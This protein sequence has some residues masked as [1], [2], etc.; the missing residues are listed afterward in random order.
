MV[1][2]ILI[3]LV[4][5]FIAGSTNYLAIK[6]LFRPRKPIYIF[7]KRLPFTPGII[8]KNR[9]RIAAALAET[10]E[11][12]FLNDEIIKKNLKF[13]Y[14]IN[15]FVKNLEN[16]IPE[17]LAL[18]DI[19]HAKVPDEKVEEFKIY[20]TNL[21]GNFILKKFDEGSFYQK[22]TESILKSFGPMLGFLG[23]IFNNLNGFFE[24]KL[25]E[26]IKTEGIKEVKEMFMAELSKIENQP[27]NAVTKKLSENYAH[28][29]DNFYVTLMS[30]FTDF[31]FSKI[32]I[33]Q[34][35]EKEMNE[36]DITEFEKVLLKII[37]KELK[38]ITYFGAILGGIIG[39]VNIF[40]I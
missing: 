22:I 35:I 21:F 23:G 5:A 24:E 15:N 31:I 17:N 26:Y 32:N 30:V 16:F 29:I 37:N 38:M 3:I 27:I 9:H 4:S 13:D 25:T 40:L 34:I 20:A 2:A 14:E 11:E 8:P 6:M 39:I 33:K 18:K 7:K 19:L 36:L 1:N 28:I 10:I 12:K